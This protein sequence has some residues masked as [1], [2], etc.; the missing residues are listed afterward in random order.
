MKK[1][2][3][4]MR[5]IVAIALSIG[6]VTTASAADMEKTPMRAAVV[7][8]KPAAVANL[9]AARDKVV[10]EVF[11]GDLGKRALFASAALKARGSRIASWR[12]PA[13]ITVKRD[14]WFL[15]VDEHPGANWE[16]PAHYILVD[17]ASGAVETHAVMTP[18]R[19][20]RALKAL[21]E[22][23]VRELEFINRNVS[24]IRARPLV[25]AVE[26]AKKD[27]YAVL[28][29]GG[30]DAGSNYGRYWNDLSSIYKAL[31]QKYGYSDDEIIVLYANGTHS[32]HADLDADGSDDVDYS[33]TKSNLTTVMGAVGKNLKS[34]GRFFF[35]ST[36][37]G[38][39]ESGYDAYLYLWGEWIRDD[40]FAALSKKI[41]AT[42]AV[43]V[44]EQCFSG[45]M[46]DDILKAQ[47]YPCTKPRVCVMTAAKHD[48]YSWGADTEGAY[49]EYVY[50]WTAAVHGKTP[51]GTAV[52]A[53]TDGNGA[54]SMS[55][56]HEYAKSHDSRNEHPLIGSCVT[57]A[58]GAVLG[59][60]KSGEDC[61]SFNPATSAVQQVNGRWKIVDGSHWVFD[62]G[63]K[64][65]EARRAF[66]IIRHYGMNRSCFVGRPDPSFTY[67][68]V[69][70][71]APAGAMSG[72][73]CVG[74]N[75]ANVAVQ[76]VNGR[77]KIVDGSHWMFD[78]GGNKTEAEQSLQLIKKH[79]FNHSCFVGRPDPSFSYLRK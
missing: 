41:V 54:V 27:K 12:K 19:E 3:V 61:V 21:N 63:N 23:A 69:S 78:F 14:S 56:A 29:S 20:L 39:Q 17:K 45:G 65:I 28:V 38:G 43:Y 15:F 79:G 18:P 68:L 8:V 52:N 42:D 57:D 7:A 37:H 26:V 48:E 71:N 16:H 58:C 75:P 46:L 47:T 67:L 13:E 62:F 34:D 74:F 40:E 30:W 9:D 70:G 55:E 64:E 66:D 24:A 22:P 53:D 73:D 60:A 6:V 49:D 11:K 51:D 5:W 50:H 25:R 2:D 35:Y 1:Q 33:A 36:N 76:Q 72:E 4:E 44:M 31:K 32:P 59:A 10:A 77:W